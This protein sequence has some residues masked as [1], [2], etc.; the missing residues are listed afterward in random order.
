MLYLQEMAGRGTH[1]CK[2]GLF[3]LKNWDPLPHVPAADAGYPSSACAAK[4]EASEDGRPG[5]VKLFK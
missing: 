3:G 1:G 2:R 4:G 5:K